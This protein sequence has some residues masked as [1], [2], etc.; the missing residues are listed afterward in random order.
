MQ[1]PEIAL[2]LLSL[3]VILLAGFGPLFGSHSR[4][5]A[6][7]QECEMFYA[8]SGRSEV[9][10]CLAEMRHHSASSPR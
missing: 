7:I 8:P 3:T 5:D 9:A 10:Q 2:I 6:V 4:A 1:L